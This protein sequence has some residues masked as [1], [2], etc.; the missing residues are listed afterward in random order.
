LSHI[1]RELQEVE[2]DL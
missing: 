1:L 2:A